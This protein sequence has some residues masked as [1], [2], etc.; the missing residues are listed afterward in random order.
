[1][2]M[3]TVPHLDL[4][5]R[6]DALQAEQP[7]TYI[8][9]A[10]ASLGVSEAELLSTRLG[11]GA[12]RLNPDAKAILADVPLLGHVTALTRNDHVVH[13]RQGTYRN[14]QLEHGPVGLFVGAD[15][16]LRIF[17]HQWAMA[18]AVEEQG[19]D[20]LR[21]SLQFFG[22]DGQAV[23]KVYLTDNSDSKAYKALVL[24]HR[25]DAQE[26]VTTVATPAPTRPELPDAAIDV[27]AFRSGWL[28]L[29][30]THDFHLLLRDHRVSRTQA[31]RLAPPDGYAV[32]VEAT[33][34]RSALTLNAERHIPIMV[35]VGNPGMIQ[36]HTGPVV[37]VVDARGWFNV[38][39]P[40]FN[41]HI[42]EEAITQV[43]VVRKPTADGLVTA[44]E[45]FD[46]KGEQL[47]QLFG[48]RKP[49]IP[50]L[51]TWRELVAELERQHAR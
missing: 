50:E 49:G 1:M 44:L 19:R 35:F 27:E 17:W 24:K 11:A 32:P 30:D 38:L 42:R 29:K 7:H 23:H 41:L 28:G 4:K 45:C 31:L 43:W 26:P 25:A 37:N 22:P 40:H 34:L 9:N 15:I 33:A 51:E 12:V 20:G 21:Q 16:D 8:R 6:W 14:P 3:I 10:A 39:D 18:F 47:I 48:A 13:E 46:D 36:I 5:A 2:I